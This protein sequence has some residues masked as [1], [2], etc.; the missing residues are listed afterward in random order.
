MYNNEKLVAL[1]RK[2]LMKFF[3][4]P[5]QISKRLELEKNGIKISYQTIYRYIY[6]GKL[7]IPK[8]WGKESL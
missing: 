6:N 1:L 2:Y 4:S 3:W 7:D 5:Q 8:W